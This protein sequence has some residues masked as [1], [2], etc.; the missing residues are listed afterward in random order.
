MATFRRQDGKPVAYA[1]EYE[2]IRSA[3]P[4][5]KPGQMLFDSGREIDRTWTFWNSKTS[6][7]E[8]IFGRRKRRI[9]STCAAEHGAFAP[10]DHDGICSPDVDRLTYPQKESA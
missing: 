1:Y 3:I 8:P 6:Q 10:H 4:T 7:I 5:V 9:C 2:V